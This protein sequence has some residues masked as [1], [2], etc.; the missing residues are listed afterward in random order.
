LPAR[1]RARSIVIPNP[2]PTSIQAN[3]PADKRVLVAVGR[4]TP[5]KGFDLLIDAFARIVG[6]FPDWRLIIWGEGPDRAALERQ[7]ARLGLAGAVQLPGTSASREAWVESAG[8]FVL[9]SR[10]EGFPNATAEAMGAG[11]PVIAFDCD[12][13]P[14]DMIDDG[15][16]GLLVR[17][18]DTEA[19]AAA[20][21]R[22]MDDF[23]LRESLGRAARQRAADFSP[24][25]VTRSWLKLIESEGKTT[26]SDHHVLKD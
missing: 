21:R 7:I 18:E 23:P 25:S 26:T 22:M 13:G 15:E 19:L 1:Q 6:E 10:Y 14:R 12:Y 2:M 5:Q 9:S 24:A 8:V 3:N 20:M 4:L 11:L 16:T 17:P